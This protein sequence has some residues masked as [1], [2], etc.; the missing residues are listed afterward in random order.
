MRNLMAIILISLLVLL[1]PSGR[2]LARTSG[3]D[4]TMAVDKVKAKIASL[5]VGEKAHAQIKLRNGQKVKG[6]V[7]GTSQ[8]NFTFTERDSG[9]TT[10]IAYRDVIEVKKRGLSKGAKIGIGAG[11]GVAVLALVFIHVRNHLFDGFRLGN[12]R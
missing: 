12:Q 8:E 1:V 11:I 3:N 2:T 9:R 5:G 10:T 7:S 4:K 6:Y